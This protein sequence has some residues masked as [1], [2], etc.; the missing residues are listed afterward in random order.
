MYH[1]LFKTY[2]HSFQAQY[3]FPYIALLSLFSFSPFSC[4]LRQPLFRNRRPNS[5]PRTMSGHHHPI[6]TPW[7]QRIKSE[8]LLSTTHKLPPDGNS[9][10][11]STTLQTRS[12][13][14]DDH[15]DSQLAGSVSSSIFN[16]NHRSTFDLLKSL[17]LPSRMLKVL[18]DL[19]TYHLSSAQLISKLPDRVSNPLVR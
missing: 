10:S 6:I 15:D 3:R 2:N 16:S 19:P 9:K 13:P 18:P 5:Q 4:R 8:V 14:N 11:P 1:T 17:P 7:L 12:E